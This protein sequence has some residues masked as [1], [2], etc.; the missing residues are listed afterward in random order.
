MK[1]PKL[2]R[3]I[4]QRKSKLTTATKKMPVAYFIILTHSPKAAAFS[5]KSPLPYNSL[6]L[7]FAHYKIGTLLL[8]ILSLNDKSCL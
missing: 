6:L 3:T 4:L 7:H 1:F 2:V 8:Q 5:Y